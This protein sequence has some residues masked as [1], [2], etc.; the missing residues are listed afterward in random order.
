M[1][2]LPKG[3]C[4]A[5]LDSL[6]LFNPK[7][8]PHTDRG[9]EVSFIPM[10]C[11]SDIDGTIIDQVI[12]PLEEIWKGYTHFQDDDVIFAK[13]TPCMEN[14][15]IAV[16]ENLHN[17]LACGSTEFHVLRTSGALLPKLL[18]YFLRQKSFREEAERHMTGA[19][20]QRRVPAQHLK[21]TIFA[22]PPLNEQR[23]IVA[24]LDSF[25]A[26]IHRAR[27]ELSKIPHLIA[28]YKQTILAAAFRGDLTAG[29]RARQQ[30]CYSVEDFIDWRIAHAN[31]LSHARELGRD[32]RTAFLYRDEDLLR[33]I[34]ERE[35]ILPLPTEWKWVGIG[36]VFGTFVGATPSRKNSSYWNGNIPWVSSGEVAFCHITETHETITEE[37]LANSSTRLHP[38]GT[39]LLGM[40]GEGK[41][42]GQAAI[43]G[44][45]ACNNQ[46][47]AAI[48][49]SEAGYPPE[50]VYW[51]LFF[52]YE[53]TRQVG[54]G[55][56][57]PA[58]NKERVQRLLIPLAPP[59]E[60][61]A[62]VKAISQYLAPLDIVRD[63]I[64]AALRQLEHLEESLLRKAFQG[65]L[66]PQDPNDEPAS[67]LLARIRDERDDKSTSKHNQR[68]KQ[69]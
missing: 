68:R 49:V 54:A 64:N 35:K 25:F 33:D 39:I 63:E 24:K 14:G 28:H 50:Y 3:W 7:H 16:A 66:V 20:G 47:S 2:E 65:E 42:R 56:N 22:L 53:R 19:V 27:N 41:T 5:T 43:L 31:A 6:C 59:E 12:R 26:R 23:R 52:E 9:T 29:W 51:F 15:K 11:V 36:E 8:E 45:Q 48:R 17:G 13:I 18:W 1:S 37:G 40:I 38:I 55:N 58:L 60:A 21:D 34:H 32:E 4:Y 61:Q 57:Q 69:Q 44:I 62:T 67:A 10:P 46:N 30:A